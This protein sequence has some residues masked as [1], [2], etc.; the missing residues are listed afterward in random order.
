MIAS[1]RCCII[2]PTLNEVGTIEFLITRLREVVP[3]ASILI[4]DDNSTDGTI[5]KV[6]TL[7]S[8][9]DQ[10]SLVVRPERLGIGSAHKF[11][12]RSAFTQGFEI[13]VTM[14]ADL[15]HNPDDVPKLLGLLHDYHMVV[16]SRFLPGGGLQDWAISR[17]V[18][19]HVGHLLTKV[20]LR[21]PFDAS[22]GFRAYRLT[23]TLLD[24]L[25]SSPSSSYGFLV[26]SMGIL[27]AAKFVV[28]EIPVVLPSRTYGHSKMRLRDLAETLAKLVST[29]RLISRE[30]LDVR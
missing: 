18:L 2:I 21:V 3:G 26:E 7:A 24:A 1:N 9:D 15:T 14:D 27:T 28:G 6:T 22:T 12:I 8:I 4:V 30:H 11:G 13:A 23:P 19:T 20:F 25:E 17:Q 29:K 16:G 10:V 5:E